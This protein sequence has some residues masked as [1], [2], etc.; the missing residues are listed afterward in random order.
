M[1]PLSIA[2]VSGSLLIA[3]FCS[4]PAAAHENG[5]AP[6]GYLEPQPCGFYLR[7]GLGGGY[8][9]SQ[10]NVNA[11]ELSLKGWAPSAFVVPGIGLSKR[12]ALALDFHLQALPSG[13]LELAGA[14]LTPRG[15]STRL[16]ISPSVIVATGRG[17]FLAP[18][19]GLAY[20]WLKLGD[21]P[22][23]K[24]HHAGLSTGLTLGWDGPVENRM[25][26]GA[27]LRIGYV[28]IPDHE[29]VKEDFFELSLEVALTKY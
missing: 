26:T 7:A 29:E 11:N 13:T 23:L 10:L 24:T 20:S 14:D 19:A 15:S 18:S 21:A 22:E 25:A 16:T 28:H 4:L 5:P 2:R 12:F 1:K 8:T 3:M 17:W 27:A 9:W 6:S